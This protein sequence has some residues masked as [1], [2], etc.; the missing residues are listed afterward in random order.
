MD[1]QLIL[2][3]MGLVTNEHRCSI[4]TRI[5]RTLPFPVLHLRGVNPEHMVLRETG[6]TEGNGL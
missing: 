1:N 4:V 2:M 3:C 6:R 5:I